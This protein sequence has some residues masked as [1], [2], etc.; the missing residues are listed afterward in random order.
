MTEHLEELERSFIMDQSAEH[1]DLPGLIRQLQ[2]FCKIDRNGHV[3]IEDNAKKLAI[4]DRI[5]LVLSARHLA[6][7]LQEK[8][9]KDIT[10]PE[11]VHSSII[12]NILKENPAVVAARLKDLKDEH[13]VIAIK[14]GT[15]KIAPYKIQAFLAA[16]GGNQ[17]D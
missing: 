17:N 16:V 10:I 13:N 7:R 3:L 4:R 2:V 5:M 14:R 6:S 12:A 15:Y 11:E 9:K 1:N 8:L